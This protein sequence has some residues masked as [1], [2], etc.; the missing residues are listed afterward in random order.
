MI[1]NYS[2]RAH[3][4][5]SRGFSCEDH[6]SNMDDPGSSIPDSDLV[7]VEYRYDDTPPSIAIV[8]AIAALEDVDPMESSAD[9][10]IVLYDQIDP[11]ALDNFVAATTDRATVSVDLVLRNDRQYTVQIRDTGWICVQVPR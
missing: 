11:E 7:R 1:G 5:A 8:R 2:L 6:S 4:I 9:L 10:G 3:G